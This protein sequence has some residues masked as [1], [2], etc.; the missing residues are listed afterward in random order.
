MFIIIID[1]FHMYIED[2][3]INSANKSV[4]NYYNV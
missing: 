1:M 4:S 3:V 2:M